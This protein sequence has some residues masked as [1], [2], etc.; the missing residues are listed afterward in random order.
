MEKTNWHHILLLAT[1]LLCAENSY[2]IPAPRKVTTITQPDGSVLKVYRK[3]DEF[4]HYTTSTDGYVL[5][6]NKDNFF[7]YAVKDSSGELQAGK[8]VAVNEEKRSSSDKQ[9]L[10]TIQPGLS[11][12]GKAISTA[13]SKRLQRISARKAASVSRGK[14]ATGLIND[15]PT[16]GSPKS[17]VILVN[18]SDVKFNAANTTAEFSSLLNE[19]GYNKNGH[20]GSARDY[21]KYNSKNVFTPD[22][23]VVGPVTVSKTRDYYGQNGA[24]GEDLHPEEMAKEACIL[25]D[26][27]VDFSQFDYNKDGYVDNIYLFYA[28]NGEADSGLE[29]TIWPHS[30]SLENNNM[31]L[32]LDGMK[33]NDYAC[34][35]E[36]N[37]L[38]ERA[39]IGTFVHEYAHILGLPDLYDVDYDYYNGQGF[40]L[41][42]W[43]VMAYG[44]YNNNSCVPPCMSVLERK[45][46]GWSTPTELTLPSSLSLQDFGSSNQGYI[47]KTNNDGEY[48]LLENRQLTK[49]PWDAYLP[50]HGSADIPYRI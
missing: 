39:G 38:D 10:Q 17:L 9:F 43:S 41:N 19:E 34:S 12:S 27:T 45:L 24:S 26:A 22:F 5:L 13:I 15:Y 32:T 31:A 4:F 40:D 20:V 25:A 30:S 46:L 18:F 2:S 48:F 33:I 47:I 21:Y 50:Y 37:Y 3:G 28:G 42:S 1:L 7:T 23:V 11:A 8:I 36:L 6:R 44:P 49:N 35:S 14:L 29:N 16:T